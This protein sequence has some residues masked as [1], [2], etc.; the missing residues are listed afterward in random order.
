MNAAYIELRD[1]VIPFNIATLKL[2][3]TVALTQADTGPITKVA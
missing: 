1:L 3:P 2:K